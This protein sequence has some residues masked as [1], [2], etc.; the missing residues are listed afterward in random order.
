MTAAKVAESRLGT[1][2]KIELVF[3]MVNLWIHFRRALGLGTLKGRSS[4]KLTTSDTSP[5]LAYVLRSAQEEG[6]SRKAMRLYLG[7]LRDSR[8][9]T[10]MVVQDALHV[11]LCYCVHRSDN[12]LLVVLEPS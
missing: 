10:A 4:G 7:K 3:D 6:H 9:P 5:I 11:V 8:G 12:Q 1:L 2:I